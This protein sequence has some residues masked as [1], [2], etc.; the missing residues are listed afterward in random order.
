MKRGSPLRVPRIQVGAVGGEEP[1]H[2]V[3][4]P[5]GGDVQRRAAREGLGVRVGASAQAQVS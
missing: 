2:V 1:D 3:E 4:A 5:L